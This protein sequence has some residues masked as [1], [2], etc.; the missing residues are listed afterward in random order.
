MNDTTAEVV[1]PARAVR[2]AETSVRSKVWRQIAIVAGVLVTIPEA[3]LLQRKYGLFTGG[4]L[5]ASPLPTWMDTAAFLAIVLL[6]NV[7]VAAPFSAI[8]LGVAQRLQLRPLARWFLA[9]AAG[10]S[11]VLAVDFLSYRLWTFVGDAFDF[12]LSYQLIGR[13]VS[14]MLAVSAPLLARPL[15]FG[16]MVATGIIA[17]TVVL[18]RLDGGRI[19]VIAGPRWR[20]ALIGSVDLAVLSAAIMTG[21]GLSSDTMR[22]GLSSMPLASAWFHVLNRLSD[23]DG[24]GY[25]LFVYPR[26]TAPFNSAVHPYALE[27]P[28]NGIDEDGVGGDL[29]RDQKPYTE[30]APP[31]SPW[32][33]R[34]PVLV[35]LLE[36]V[37]ADVVGAYYHGR[38]VTPTL[39]ALARTGLKVESAWSHNGFT[40]QSRFHMLTG[41]MIGRDGTSLLDDFKNHGYDVAYF[42]AQDDTAFGATEVNRARIDKYFDARQDVSQRYSTYTT[43]GS[44]A[45]PSGVLEDQIYEYLRDRKGQHP[46]FMYVNFQDTHYPYNHSWLKPIMTSDP[47]ATSLIAPS[48]R[49]DLWATYLNATANVDEAIGRVIEAVHRSVG[50]A[51]AAIVLSDHGESLFD[52]GFLG[53]G[54]VLNTPQTEI[55]M[56][57]SG[58]P[59]RVTVPFGQ[60][61]LRD[62]IDNA[63]DGTVSLDARPTVVSNG[64]RVFQYLGSL[65]APGEIAWLTREGRITYDFRTNHV[66]LWDSTLNPDALVGEP[67]KAFLDLVYTWER[68]RLAAH[69]AATSAAQDRNQ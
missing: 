55:P 11:P 1:L 30:P 4:F 27:V 6:L 66:G 34:P 26:D 44:L 43:P 17:M 52:G 61:D 18:H 67:K 2:L 24:D 50:V 19:P 37:R 32:P 65:E 47:L 45:I 54:Y 51:P 39:D 14:E 58:L 36:S 40:R 22:R 15:A 62:S 23:F 21:V 8:A 49:S 12:R 42:S 56:I 63:L 46:L 60:A 7:T 33:V 35:F 3:L 69:K 9:I 29:P 20:A 57:V 48:R 10:S 53:H 59:L 31:T 28:G 5:S 41:S 16:G 64:G 13:R 68:M 25:G 38:P